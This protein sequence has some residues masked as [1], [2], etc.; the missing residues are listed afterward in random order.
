MEISGLNFKN[1]GL[2]G[3]E[4]KS[5]SHTTVSKTRKTDSVVLSG[6]AQRLDLDL[7]AAMESYDFPPRL[8][9]IRNVEQMIADG[10]LNSQRYLEQVAES[11]IA[12]STDG[13]TVSAP[14]TGS[15]ETAVRQKNVDKASVQAGQNYYDRQEVLE[16]TA[17]SL[18]GV[19]R[20]SYRY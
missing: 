16:K 5:S 18:I 20:I 8:D 10:T 12:A 1:G 13:E 17:Q 11:L 15:T 6:S 14:E 2:P 3:I 9:R 7:V 19:L 4:T